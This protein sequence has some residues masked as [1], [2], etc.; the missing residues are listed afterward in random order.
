MINKKRNKGIKATLTKDDC[1]IIFRTARA[2]KN[3]GS[4]IAFKYAQHAVNENLEDF[5][6]D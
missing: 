6:N 3:V 2:Y 5:D 1:H 4:D